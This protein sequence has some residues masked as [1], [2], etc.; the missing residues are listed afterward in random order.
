MGVASP[1]VTAVPAR[2][3]RAKLLRELAITMRAQAGAR[4]DG[5]LHVTRMLLVGENLLHDNRSI[6]ATEGQRCSALQC[7]PKCSVSSVCWLPIALER[8]WSPAPGSYSHRS[9]SVRPSQGQ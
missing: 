4:G 2:V 5:E 3:I 1:T 8:T 9:A 7:C 6:G